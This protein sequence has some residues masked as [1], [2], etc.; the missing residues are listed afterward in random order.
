MFVIPGTKPP[1]LRVQVLA[2][3]WSHRTLK[4]CIWEPLKQNKKHLKFLHMKEVCINWF[5]YTHTHP[6]M[7]KC[8]LI[9]QY[10]IPL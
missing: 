7:H 8:I 1:V 4:T 3:D 5:F 9:F 6:N 2:V 10:I